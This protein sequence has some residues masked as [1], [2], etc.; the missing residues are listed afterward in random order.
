MSGAATMSAYKL[1][2]Q[3]K[4]GLEWATHVGSELVK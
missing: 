4:I 3:A 2:T 1:P